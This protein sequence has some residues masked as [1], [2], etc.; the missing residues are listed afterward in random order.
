MPGL[1]AAER[2]KQDVGSLLEAS[3]GVAREYGGVGSAF[4]RLLLADLSLSRVA[5]VRGLVFLL[6]CALAAGTAWVMAMTMLIV[7]LWQLGL[8]WMV[9]FFVPLAISVGVAWVAWL[10]ARKALSYS[11][12]DA[13]RRQLAI[14][15]PDDAPSVTPAGSDQVDAAGTDSAAPKAS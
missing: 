12:F 4:R 8:P 7:G 3:R 2:L 11:D 1:D 14:W 6:L 9:A 15:F 10:H 13:T 5:L